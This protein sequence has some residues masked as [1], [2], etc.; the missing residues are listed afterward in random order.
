REKIIQS[1]PMDTRGIYHGGPHGHNRTVS[2]ICS[3]PPLSLDK[4]G[5]EAGQGTRIEPEGVQVSAVR[6]KQPYHCRDRVCRHV[7]LPPEDAS[8][9]CF[10]LSI[11]LYDS[12]ILSLSSPPRGVPLQA[13]ARRP[14][15]ARYVSA[16]EPSRMMKS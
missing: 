9:S 4:G 6:G 15:N 1:A 13:T 10:Q 11:F 5:L 2:G 16:A 7:D 3:G 12:S 8:C 14:W